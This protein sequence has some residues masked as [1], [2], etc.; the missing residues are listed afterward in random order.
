MARDFGGVAHLSAR[1]WA[2]LVALALAACSG[3]GGGGGGGNQLSISLTPTTL[4]ATLYQG[5]PSML[6]VNAVV[7][8][9]VSGNVLV[10]LV[11]PNKVL[12]PQ[13]VL[14]QIGSNEYAAS[15]DTVANLALGAHNGTFQILICGDANCNTVYGSTNLPYAFT[16]NPPPT[17]SSLVPSGVAFGG[18]A[19]LLT[20]NG[21]NF[22][23]SSIV[24]WNGSPRTTIYISPTQVNA[25]IT[26]AD[27][28]SIITVPVTVQSGGSSGPLTAALN[29]TVGNPLPA[30]SSFSPQTVQADGPGFTIT[31]NGSDFMPSAVVNWNG[32]PRGTTYVSASQLTASI[33]SADI[34]AGGTFAITVTNPSP[35]GGTSQSLS[36][37][38]P[39]PVP[40]VNLLN[41]SSAPAGCGSFLLAVAGSSVGPESQVLWN[42]LPR[43]TALIEP[44]VVQAQIGAA[45]IAA[46]GTATVTVF[47]PPPGGGTSNSATF[48]INANT[49]PTT[50]ATA[51]LVNPAH[52]GMATTN[53]PV[54]L[55]VSS[56]WSFSTPGIQYYPLIAGDSVFTQ[57]IN[58]NLYS[59][60]AGTGSINWGP[61]QLNALGPAYDTGALYFGIGSVQ[62][63]N[64]SLNSYDAATGNLRYSVT[65]PNSGASPFDSATVA[66]NGVVYEVTDQGSVYA[67]KES[68]GSFLWE[69]EAEFVVTPAVTASGVYI[70][71]GC[72]TSDL[73]IATGLGTWLNEQNCSGPGEAAP[74]VANGVVYA[75]AGVF[76]TLLEV[77]NA[78]TGASLH[79]I[80]AD[81]Q[82]AFGTQVGYFLQIGVLNAINLS[83]GATLWSFS[84]DGT[85]ISAPVVVNQVVFIASASG[86]LYALD[87]GTGTELWNATLPSGAATSDRNLPFIF[88]ASIA[89][90]DGYLAVPTGHTLT[91][92]SISSSH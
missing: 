68:D 70:S 66:V 80:I 65:L 23:T 28:T 72:A 43:P 6:S 44:T 69:T 55:P 90:G 50:E 76:P 22:D 61:N 16:V 14:S 19:F 64:G 87:A 48:T 26:Q 20:V 39:N 49:Q 85:L 13:I 77:F 9:S 21:S 31:V 88:G 3:G 71:S 81:T 59:F 33:T 74:V 47:N 25:Q 8:G 63:P 54:S 75:P 45:D 82:P 7:N 84:G 10:V 12:Q 67:M 60:N 56:A 17:L 42:G 37:T 29:F 46:M 1:L 51:Y 41:A 62:I 24:Q 30:L 35:G 86:Q 73:S 89:A 92:Y 79:N 32:S 11:D 58:G 2:A 53:C 36:I 40:A 5:F 83:S 52:N 91:V 78:S 38:V 18:P 15:F 34:L 27:L 4:N 57:D